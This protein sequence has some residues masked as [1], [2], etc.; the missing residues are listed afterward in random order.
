MNCEY[1]NIET[2]VRQVDVLALLLFA[3]FTDKLGETLK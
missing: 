3:M 2:E 1:F